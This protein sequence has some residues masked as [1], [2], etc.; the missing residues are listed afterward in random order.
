MVRISSPYS[1]SLFLVPFLWLMRPCSVAQVR[2]GYPP[3]SPLT[4]LIPT[5]IR[6]PLICRRD[7]T[8]CPCLVV[9]APLFAD[10]L[11]LQVLHLNWRLEDTRTLMTPPAVLYAD[12]VSKPSVPFGV[13]SEP[14][15]GV[16]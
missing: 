11:I 14:E 15:R 13:S 3:P 16:H 9:T 1:F 8:R 4:F 2:Q 10:R 6:L 5:A 7:L 12:S